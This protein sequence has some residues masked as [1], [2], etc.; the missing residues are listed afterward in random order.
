MR[1]IVIGRF[2]RASEIDLDT[3]EAIIRSKRELDGIPIVANASF[4][5]TMPQFTFPIGGH[6]RLSAAGGR[7]EIRIY[8]H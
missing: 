6:G 3:L 7:V 2:Q 1:G 8:E 5:H 4:G